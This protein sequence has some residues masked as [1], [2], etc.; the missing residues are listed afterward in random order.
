MRFGHDPSLAWLGCVARVTS[1]P[2]PDMR[3]PGPDRMI[4]GRAGIRLPVSPSCWRTCRARRNR[5]CWRTITASRLVALIRATRADQRGDLV[6]VVVLAHLGPGL[7]GHAVVG[8]GEPGAL[9]GERQRG[10]LGL[11]EHGGLAPGGDQVEPDRGL[12]GGRG[13]LGVDVDAPAA[14]VD[15][16]G[17]QRHQL[18]GGLGQ[19]RLL[20]HQ[21]DVVDPLGDLGA[22]LVGRSGRNGVP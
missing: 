11:G 5:P 15:L 9:L 4:L 20:D 10:P 8:V 2:E 22:D 6:V 7:V 18:L 13:L 14:A 1:Q 3:G 17:A 21:V 19:R 16:A 12:T